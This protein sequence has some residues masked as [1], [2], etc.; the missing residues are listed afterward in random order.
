[1]KLLLLL[2]SALL[3]SS[4]GAIKAYVKDE[5]VTWAQTDGKKVVEEKVTEV[6]KK[7]APELLATI[8]TNKNGLLE[9]D[10]IK[11][12]NFADPS[13]WGV[14]IYAVYQAFR[15]R[16]TQAELDDLYDRNASPPVGKPQ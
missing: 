10:E 9:W 1:M 13:L 6:V 3:F 16:R 14:I 5:V 15:N 12:I 8:D 2:L 11:G 7:E 4:C